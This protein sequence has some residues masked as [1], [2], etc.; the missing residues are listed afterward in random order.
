MG[1]LV[2]VIN[3]N[4]MDE[5]QQSG[6]ERQLVQ[7]KEAK[8][9]LW[10]P[11]FITLNLEK[12]PSGQPEQ[13]TEEN[14]QTTHVAENPQAEKP[15]EN[16]EPAKEQPGETAEKAKTPINILSP[17]PSQAQQA[18]QQQD[19]TKKVTYIYNLVDHG[20]SCDCIDVK[21]ELLIRSALPTYRKIGQ[22]IEYEQISPNQAKIIITSRVLDNY[23]EVFQGFA[24]PKATFRVWI[25]GYKYN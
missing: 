3:N 7:V 6:E 5:N 8:V 24:I 9:L 18:K 11:I 1:L 25:I 12:T 23:Q 17:A 4:F 2:R 14:S 16:H 20:L 21:G 13:A 10:G 15:P 22:G 19:N